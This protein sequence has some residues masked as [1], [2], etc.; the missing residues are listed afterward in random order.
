MSKKKSFGKK[1]RMSQA[2]HARLAKRQD[3][4]YRRTEDGRH[5]VCSGYHG[6]VYKRQETLGR[7]LTEEEKKKLY[8]VSLWYYY[9]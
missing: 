1:F 7:V 2:A 9:N 5:Y 8:R 6:S 3:E 4:L